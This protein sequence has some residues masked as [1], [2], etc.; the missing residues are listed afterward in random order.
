ME[1]NFQLVPM[2]ITNLPLKW[3]TPNKCAFESLDCGS[4]W[5][6]EHSHMEIAYKSFDH[7]SSWRPTYLHQQCI[8]I[9]ILI[10]TALYRLTMRLTLNTRFTLFTN[11]DRLSL[12]RSLR[13]YIAEVHEPSE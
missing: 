7:G 12:H 9:F 10:Q 4:S 8:D 3:H 2:A 13:E 11:N 5:R 1:Q 6:I